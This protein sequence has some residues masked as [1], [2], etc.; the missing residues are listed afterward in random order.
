VDVKTPRACY[1]YRDRF[2]DLVAA[3][4]GSDKTL[5]P[6]LRSPSVGE[7]ALVSHTWSTIL[8]TVAGYHHARVAA[9][10]DGLSKSSSRTRSTLVRPTPSEKMARASPLQSGGRRPRRCERSLHSLSETPP[11]SPEPSTKVTR[12]PNPQ[13]V[14]ERRG[15]ESVL[16]V[17]VEQKQLRRDVELI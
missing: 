14:R 16:Y 13:L 4:T 2:P 6:V 3:P 10:P 1:Q 11:S 15:V 5:N 9:E 7:S 8:G 12:N 17:L